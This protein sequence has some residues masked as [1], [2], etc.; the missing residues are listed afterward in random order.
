M[1]LLNEVAEKLNAIFNG[2]D[3]EINNLGIQKPNDFYFMVATTGFHLDNIKQENVGTNFIP[4]FI[5]SMGGDYNAVPNLKQSTVSIPIIFYFPVRFKNDFFALNEFLANCFVG[6][7][8]TWG[9]STGKCISNISVSQFGEIQDLDLR[10]FDNWV[11]NVYQKHID[12]MEKYMSMMF[13]LYLTNSSSNYIYGNSVHYSLSITIDSETYS[14]DDL[15]WIQ[16]GTGYNNSPIAQQLV[17]VDN[18]AKNTVNIANFSKSILVYPKLNNEF[19]QKF[20]DMYNNQDSNLT[21]PLTQSLTL[22]KTYDIPKESESDYIYEYDQI[23]LS[24]N[25]NIARGDLISYTITFGDS[26]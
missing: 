21:K 15:D 2:T 13:N 24:I 16:A 17:G 8:L 18:F 25:E 12:R 23:I 1:I 6:R 11:E 14:D 26:I 7:F 10:E 5:D 19:W 4:V 9:T 20:I 3:T 22:T